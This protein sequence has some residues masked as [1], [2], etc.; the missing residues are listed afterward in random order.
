MQASFARKRLNRLLTSQAFGAGGALFACV[1]DM[2][3]AG[4]FVGVDALA[5]IAVVLPVIVGAQFVSRLIYCGAGYL[6]AKYQGLMDS[7]GARRVVGLSL[8]AAF[9]VGVLIF[10]VTLL[11]RDFYLD[12]MGLS[13]AVRE[14]ATLYWRWIM[15]FYSICPVSM[16]MWRLVYADGEAVT[17]AVADTLSPP[18]TIALSIVFTKM[19]GS[20]AGAALGVLI[21]ATSTD[22][23]MMLH[24]F[25][26]SNAVVPTWN[27]SWRRLR[28]LMSYSLTDSV[29]K[30]CQCAF[31][32]VVNKLVILMASAAYLPVV[33]MI[34]LV[35]QLSDLLDRIGDAYMP[36][37]EM[38]LGERNLPRLRE[39]ARYS[40]GLS[41]VLGLILMGVVESLAPQ[42]VALYGI[43]AGDVFE[44]SVTALRISAVAF[45]IVS[46]LLF[47]SSHYLVMERIFLSVANTISTGFLLTASCAA[48]FCLTWGLDALWIGLP[49]GVF[50]TLTVLIVYCKFFEAHQPPLLIPDQTNPVLNLTF[51]P[52]G[53]QVVEARDASERFL[54]AN[55]VCPET[56]A[57]VMLLIE[58]CVMTIADICRSPRRICVEVTVMVDEQEVF[59]ILRDTGTARDLTDG[60]A[61][62]TS[63]RRFVI[64]GLMQSFEDRRY[65]NTIGCNRAVFS[66][67]RNA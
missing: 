3:V 23:I 34:A 8:E 33:S 50:L 2:I 43:P 63:L 27:F 19:T 12:L 37:A 5:G 67:K 21:G 57:R 38:Y 44:H 49:V 39:L 42:I 40:T 4:N 54:G 24:V 59:L 36:V 48:V 26:R 16:T 31:V 62:V 60:D 58:E 17:T 46:V 53:R 11:G 28:E 9:C 1:T 35:Q 41:F 6:F 30:L 66:L 51:A 55:A 20:A 61:K 65:L 32:T 25:R 45:P 64:A 29:S 52:E 15:V 7:A 22:L 18:L 47:L 56:I 14:Q 10:T 13:G